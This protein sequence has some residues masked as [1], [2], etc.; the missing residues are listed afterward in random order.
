MSVLDATLYGCFYSRGQKNKKNI[1]SIAD[2]CV[3]KIVFPSSRSVQLPGEYWGIITILW[4]KATEEQWWEF[5]D[6]IPGKQSFKQGE[7][8]L[9]LATGTILGTQK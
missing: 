7:F 1:S 5:C 6:E 8:K 3:R 2:Y 4:E 9:L